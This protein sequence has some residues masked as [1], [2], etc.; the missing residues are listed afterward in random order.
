M[1][2]DRVIYAAGILA[3]LSAALIAWAVNHPCG[4][5][6]QPEVELEL[7]EREAVEE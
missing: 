5:E 1:S 7:I 6:D 4:C 3:V 2:R